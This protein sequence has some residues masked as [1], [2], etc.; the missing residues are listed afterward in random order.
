MSKGLLKLAP[1]IA[2]LEALG[3][4]ALDDFLADP[5]ALVTADRIR[6]RGAALEVPLPGTPDE[7]GRQRER[8][9]GAGTGLLLLQR[10]PSGGI[11]GLR[12][13]LTHPRSTSR[14]ARQWNLICHLQANGVAAPQLVALG[15]RGGAPLG[16]ESFL[17][18]RALEGFV[19]VARWLAEERDASR[20][21]RGLKSIAL[22]CAQTLRCGAWLPRTTLSGLSIHVEDD[23]CAALKIVN[24]KSEQALLRTR[25][26]VRARLPAVA[27]T[28]F[29]RG[30][31][32]SRISARRR[33][34][35]LTALARE[36]RTLTS[37][38]ERAVFAAR[39]LGASSELALLAARCRS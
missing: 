8:P 38:R 5:P 23:S 24:L 32:L 7:R 4:H 39:I 15:E 11:E 35:W 34:Q 14:A 30:R 12:A 3:A 29:E 26:L 25:G 1:D 36:A 16:A 18:T 20:R 31:I 10:F 19:P 33:D 9:R 37:E 2:S 28:E 6:P 17:L 27:F 13:R 21:R 22:A